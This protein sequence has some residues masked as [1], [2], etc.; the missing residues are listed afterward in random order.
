MSNALSSGIST[1]KGAENQK[2]GSQDGDP[3]VSSEGK[4]ET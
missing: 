2:A 1:T 3:C 4:R